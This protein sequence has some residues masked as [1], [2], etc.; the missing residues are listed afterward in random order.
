MPSKVITIFLKMAV[1]AEQD[2]DILC[3]SS[4]GTAML[5]LKRCLQKQYPTNQ[6]PILETINLI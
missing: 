1:L 6:I 3:P 4:W 5:K 2:V